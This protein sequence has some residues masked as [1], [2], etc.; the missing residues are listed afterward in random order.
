[1]AGRQI[2]SDVPLDR[3]VVLVDRNTRRR[4]RSS[5]REAWAESRGHDL[6]TSSTWSYARDTIAYGGVSALVVPVVLG[7]VA[8]A[9]L[10]GVAFGAALLAGGGGTGSTMRGALLIL[11]SVLVSQVLTAARVGRRARRVFITASLRVMELPPRWGFATLRVASPDATEA[12]RA[13]LGG[14]FEYVEVTY[15]RDRDY[16]ELAAYFRVVATTPHGEALV[17]AALGASPRYMT[18]GIVLNPG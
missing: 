12:K 14:A 4:P 11:A 5:W 8:L 10:V 15:F 6:S 2:V 1:M 16:A 9:L 18:T 17:A 7:A 3:Q 13:L